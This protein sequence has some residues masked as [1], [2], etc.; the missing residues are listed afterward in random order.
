MGF[1]LSN[2]QNNV[3][4]KLFKVLLYIP[5]RIIYVFIKN[6]FIHSNFMIEL[7]E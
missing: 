2:V 1:F 3:I 6:T 4:I 7:I 5:S